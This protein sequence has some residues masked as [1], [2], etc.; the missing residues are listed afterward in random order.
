MNAQRSRVRPGMIV[1]IAIVTLLL[2]SG[3]IAEF[4]TDLLWY[5]DLGQ[6]AVFWRTL[7]WRWAAGSLSAVLFFALLYV[8]L[9]IARS[10]TPAT[11]VRALDNSPSARFEQALQQIRERVGQVGGRVVLGASVA[12]SLIAGSAVAG[13]WQTLALAV[14]GGSFGVTDPQFGRDLGFYFFTL[15]ALRMAEGWLFGALVFTLLATAVVHLLNGSIRPW[16]RWRG[17]DPHVKAHLSVLGGLIVVTQAF[18]YWVD[19]FELNFS[20]RG[21]VVGASF[22]DVHAQIPAY[23]ILI[24][25]ALLCGLA[26]IVNIRFRGWRLPALA[27]GT[28][29]AAA[30]IIGSAYPAVVQQFR[31]APNEVEAESPYIER[32]IAATRAAF[33]LD[34]IDVR[35]FAAEESL[36]ASD[37]ADNDRTIQNVR[38]WDPAIVEQTYR[39][40][41]GIRPY[42]DFIDVDIDRYTIDGVRRQVLVSARELDVTKL[43]SQAQTWVNQHLVYTHGSGLVVSPVNEVSG[44]GYPRFIVKDI[45]PTSDTDLV[46][47]Q[48]ALY[49]G[50]GTTNYVIAATDL[51][52]FDY[53]V[54]D[55]NA[56]TTY[57]GAGGIE[58]GGPLKRAA[59]ALRF[60]APQILFSGYIRS[61]SK[62]LL[63][64]SI[65][66]RIDALAPWLYT[67]SD[68][69]PVIADGRIVWVADCYTV[70]DRYPYAERY[71]GISYIRNSVKVTVDAYDGTTTLYA[72]DPDDPLLAAWD[73]VF[74]GLLTSA[75][76]MPAEIT[77]HLR[78]PSDLFMM[79]AEV[80]KTYHMLDPK[81]FYNKEDQWALP[82]EGSDGSGQAMAP[83]Y[84]L[85]ELPQETEEDFML[86]LPFTPRTK[87]N[88]IGWMAAK[89]DPGS[90]GERVV[91]TFPKQR[92]VLGPEQVQARVNQDPVISQQLSLWNQRG[93]GVLFGNLL[94]I[95]VNDS[96]VYIQPLYLQAEQTA[97]PQLTRVI[98]AYGDSVAMEP[99]LPSALLAVF[100]AVA[101]TPVEGGAVA[102]VA[103]AKDLYDKAVEAQKAGDWEA[104][105]RYLRELG[106]VLEELLGAVPPASGTG[107][108]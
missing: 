39:Q 42:Y 56:E 17:F 69:Y 58:I 34:E 55:S 87:A 51:P 59:F 92:L 77:E 22:T 16:D 8:N 85:M 84:V 70:S 46:I 93:S 43:A 26:L 6:S 44:Q 73:V 37:L 91:Y 36:L 99:D 19:I 106:T 57:T 41:Q 12:A 97:M 67:D 86:M 48:P 79:Q 25:I 105:G 75:D 9:R 49:F 5:Q 18:G 3:A 30:V 74:P 78:Y 103:T 95:P 11:T 108:P 24:V 2:L 64:R 101:E 104:Y 96:I 65:Q 89:S 88:M 81:V 31:V 14:S 66:E 82:G 94:V 63:R 15:P 20:P 32:N 4:Y 28:W 21:Q 72:F 80:Y 90:Y 52:E 27:L 102:D 23:T 45:P 33:G 1:A 10:M 47:E 54:G 35:A 83:F 107:A 40:L 7:G 62:V 29:I 100:G 13:S 38:L 50:E 71:G 76:E 53:P 60:S 61:D 98:V 68:P